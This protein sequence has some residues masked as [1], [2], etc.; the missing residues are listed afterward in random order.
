METS[1]NSKT[2]EFNL[3]GIKGLMAIIAPFI[4]ITVFM[5]TKFAMTE[6]LKEVE[7]ESKEYARELNK[8]TKEDIKELKEQQQDIAKEMR[9]QFMQQRILLEKALLEKSK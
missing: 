4:L 2:S 9:E 6:D 7:K 1:R 5:F 3:N 8:D